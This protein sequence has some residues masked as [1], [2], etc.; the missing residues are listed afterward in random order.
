MKR[1]LTFVPLAMLIGCA[2]VP[3]ANVEPA[4]LQVA[5]VELPES[6]LLD[7]GV[8]VFRAG[9][10]TTDQAREEGQSSDV[11]RAETVYIPQHLRTTLQT[12]GQWGAVWVVPE[13]SDAVDVN[14]AGEILSS[15]GEHLVL[16]VQARDASGRIWLERT[17]SA[18]AED[19]SYGTP[20]KGEY[21]PY[22]D[23][24]NAIANDLLAF[25]QTL[26]AAQKVE[27]RRV[28]RL[29]Y[30]QGLA[31]EVFQ[32]YLLL[33]PDGLLV[34][35]RLPARDD[36]MMLRLLK[37][38]ER[39][40]MFYDTI[41]EHYA[42]LYDQM[43]DPYLNW[44][45]AQLEE[46]QA[47]RELKRQEM[48]RKVLSVA[49]IAGAVAYEA[50]S[51]GGRYHSSAAT[52]AMILGGMAA[53]QSGSVK[54]QEAEMHAESLRELGTSFEEEIQ[55]QVVE[56]EGRTLKLTGTASQ[57]YDE[58]RRLLREIYASETGLLVTEPPILAEPTPGRPL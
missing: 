3:R 36:P 4:P 5:S 8:R 47:Y 37:V 51:R 57:Q 2:T 26:T 22:Q 53:W 42:D 16:Q 44:R 34:A 28:A 24:Y 11:R 20:R 50:T 45:R 30:A 33:Q 58:W 23:V 12:S 29:R 27:I 40:F 31:P 19:V 6:E 38:R 41:D 13:E 15:S 43:W 1:V 21:D 46:V 35:D 17:Y 7:V 39:E 49:A 9:A 52:S 32:G 10:V 25:R 18:V 14:V 48:I 54:A 56:L 55:P